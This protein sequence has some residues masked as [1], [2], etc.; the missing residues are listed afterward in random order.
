M[1]IQLNDIMADDSEVW[2]KKNATFGYDLEI[3]I[4]GQGIHFKEKQ[5]HEYAIDSLAEFCRR[6]LHDYDNANK[7]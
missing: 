2:L 5:I 7:E 3:N 6:F 4:P 1:A